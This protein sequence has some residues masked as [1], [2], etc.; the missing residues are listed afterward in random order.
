MFKELQIGNKKVALLANGATPLRY[1][2][3]FNRDIIAEFSDAEGQTSID[4]I[5][6]LAYV[7]A[8]QAADTIKTADEEGFYSWLEE[9]EALDITMVAKD[10]IDVYTKNLRG[11]STAKKKQPARKGK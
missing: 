5:A 9:F 2:Q 1:K 10:I 3:I 11:T 8:M 4:F 6:P 7:M